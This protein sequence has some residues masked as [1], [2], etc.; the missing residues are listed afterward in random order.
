[1]SM[2]GVAQVPTNQDCLGAIAICQNTFTESN[3][4][5]GTG[6]YLNEIDTVSSCLKSGEKNDVWYTFTVQTSGSLCFTITPNLPSD[7]Y[8]W[9][10][11]IPG[12]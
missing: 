4:Y 5:S 6:N 2:I 7:D 1:M 12:G 3:A 9:A 8:D 11:T 10:H